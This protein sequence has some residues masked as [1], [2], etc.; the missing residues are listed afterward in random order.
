M[1]E[2]TMR[3]VLLKLVE[4]ST[5]LDNALGQGVDHEARLRV[6]E[7]RQWAA[8]GAAA[9]VGGIAGKVAGLL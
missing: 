6:L 1:A 2:D 8:M 9:A 5:K 7:K 3:D 4:I